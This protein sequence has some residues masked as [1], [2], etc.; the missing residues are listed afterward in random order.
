LRTA[1]GHY[2]DDRRA[3]WLE[4][5]FDL[6]FAGAVGQLAGALQDHPTMGGLV[7]FAMLFTPIWWL[8]VMFTFYADRHESEDGMHRAAFLSAM[9]LCVALAA[10][11]ARALSGETPA[12]SSPSAACAG[13]SW[14]C[15]R[16][17][18]ATCQPQEPSTTAIWCSSAPP[19]RCGWPRSR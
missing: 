10:S 8:W 1:N 3:S 13:C 6:V 2:R 19:G 4:L 11:A 12:S 16:G 14:P 7:R 5:F 9:L 18:G 17:R 15:M